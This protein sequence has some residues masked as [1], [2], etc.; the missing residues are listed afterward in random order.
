MSLGV[1]VQRPGRD[2]LR[3]FEWTR[4]AVRWA[5][6]VGPLTRTALKAKAPVG[7]GQGAGR[8]RDSIRYQRRTLGGAVVLEFTANTPYAKY[9]LSGTSAHEIRPKAARVLH[10]VDA[11]GNDRFAAAVRHPGTKPN[12]FPEKAVLPLLPL[13]QRRFKEIVTEQ[14]RG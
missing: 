1:R 14:L 9:V 5:D 4:L 3:R 6:E 8:L 2:P 11:S 10:W 7:K 12:R 13:I